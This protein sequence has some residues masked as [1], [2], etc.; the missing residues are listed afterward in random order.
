[1]VIQE[2]MGKKYKPGEAERT[3]SF[4]FYGRLAKRVSIQVS[5]LI[6]W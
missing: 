3:Y 4:K 2:L 1:M 5:I 6:D